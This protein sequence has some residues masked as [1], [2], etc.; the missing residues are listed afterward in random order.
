MAISAKVDEGGLKTGL[1]PGDFGFVDVCFSLNALPVLDV[2]IIKPLAINHRDPNL[3]RLGGVNQYLFHCCFQ[4]ATQP[5]GA[6]IN[7]SPVL[8]FPPVWVD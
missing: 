7:E 3:L 8:A 4:L 2:Q 5:G 6:G 1:N